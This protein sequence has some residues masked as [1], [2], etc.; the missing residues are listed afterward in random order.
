VDL[1]NSRNFKAGLNFFFNKNLNHL[2]LEFQVNHGVSAYGP[3]SMTNAAT[4]AGYFPALKYPNGTVVPTTP[5]D[6]R[7]SLRVVAQKSFLVHWAVLF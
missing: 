1:G 5:T 6:L 7:T 3:Q 4:N 2:N